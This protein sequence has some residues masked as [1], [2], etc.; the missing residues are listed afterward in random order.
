METSTARNRTIWN[1][2]IIRP[3]YALYSYRPMASPTKLSVS[4]IPLTII[5][6]T[7]STRAKAQVAVRLFPMNCTAGSSRALIARMIMGAKAA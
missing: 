7:V 4:M 2:R 6:M 3:V 1:S 5:E